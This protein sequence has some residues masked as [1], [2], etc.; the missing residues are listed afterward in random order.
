MSDEHLRMSYGQA[1]TYIQ[2]NHSTAS[3]LVMYLSS[4]GISFYLEI[5]HASTGL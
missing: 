4:H 3:C 1:L 5:V 2:Q